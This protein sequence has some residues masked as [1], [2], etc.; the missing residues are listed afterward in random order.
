MS[1]SDDGTTPTSPLEDL[2]LL[3][4]QAVEVAPGL[5]HLELYTPAG[6]LTLLWHGPADA[7]AVV[8]CVGGAM[9]G[10]L[11]P[12]E[13]MYHRLGRALADRGIGVLRVGYR[14][15]ARLDRCVH[16]TLAVLELAARHG[17]RRFVPVGHSFGGAVAVQAAMHLDAASVP[18]VVTLATQSAGC[19]RAELLADRDLLL[20]HGSAD[21]I[22]PP[23]ASHLV[24]HLAGVGEVVIVPGADHLFRPGWEEVLDRLVV[25]LPT[26][27]ATP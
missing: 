17:A 22:L 1:A 14:N 19:E 16:D 15:P 21:Q 27:L 12:A 10:L 4:M 8:V 24:R 2:G 6:L 11:G 7:E 13:G 25:H 23:D 26:I 18:G 5:D 20:F 9:G 3:A